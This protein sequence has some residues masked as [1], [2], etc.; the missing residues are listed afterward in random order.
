MW[1]QC[2][3]QT[4]QFTGHDQH[5]CQ[6]V[7]YVQVKAFLSHHLNCGVKREEKETETTI[8]SYSNTLT[9]WLVPT[10]EYLGHV[11]SSHQSFSLQVDDKGW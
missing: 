10:A 6:V 5:T 11:L 1:H 8:L 9:Y 2:S 3:Q 7:L 4:H